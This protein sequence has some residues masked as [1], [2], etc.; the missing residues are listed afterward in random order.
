MLVVMETPENERRDV[1]EY[2]RSQSGP[3]FSIEHVEKLTAEYVLGRQY[4]V[5]DAHTNEGR[6]WLITNPTNL[7][8]QELIKS[9]DIALSFHIGLMTR[10]AAR[11]SVRFKRGGT[12]DWVLEVL[13]RQEAA[14]DSLDRAKEVEDIQA[15]GMR[16]RENLLTLIEKFHGL[17]LE[18]P[19][20][21]ELPEQN[22]NFKGWA[23]IYAGVLAPG[24][25]LENLR[26]LLKSQSDRT[27]EYL[28][29]LTHARNANIT[30][31][32]IAWSATDALIDMFLFAVARME[33]GSIERCP[34][35]SSYQ[36]SRELAE[37]RGWTQ[38]C[39]T[40][41]WSGSVDPPAPIE[42]EYESPGEQP[43]EVEGDCA[44]PEDFGIY[45]TPGQARSML[46]EDT[47]ESEDQDEQPRWMNPFAFRFPEDNSVHDV[48]RLVFHSFNHEP[49]PGTEFIYKCEDDNCVNP[50]HAEEKSLPEGLNWSPMVVERVLVSG[51]S[52]LDLTIS[53]QTKGRMNLSIKSDTLNRYGLGD[54]S[55]LLERV[56]VV[57]EPDDNGR[58]SV[59]LA[60]R[61]VDF[62]HGTVIPGRMH[63][64]SDAKVPTK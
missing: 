50:R 35:C 22:G 14:S 7:Y 55:S 17:R 5:W 58:V 11:D 52:Y 53:S 42:N 12:R 20:G 48:H 63:P 2:L 51:P 60:D 13:R 15:V 64:S 38:Q 18:M 27:W 44:I 24:S 36:L 9:M 19:R 56:V 40:C 61:R 54:A 41:G 26:K 28:G 25:S 6:W 62:H 23:R 16:L 49:T 37:G 33:T 29:W 1:E 59:V 45:L 3:D 4:D 39:S 21:T 57:S 32:R 10:M 43:S 34:L 47:A 30:D 8:S 31:G 46:E